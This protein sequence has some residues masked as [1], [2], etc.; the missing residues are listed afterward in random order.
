MESYPISC[1]DSG[2][3]IRPLCCG[4][5]YAPHF[6]HAITATVI[7]YGYGY[8][9]RPRKWTP[10]SS[11]SWHFS[12][13]PLFPS[14]LSFRLFVRPSARSV[15]VRPSL[16]PDVAETR[17]ERGPSDGASGALCD[18]IKARRHR[19]EAPFSESRWPREYQTKKT[20]DSSQVGHYIM[21]HV[22]SY[23]S[24]SVHSGSCDDT[25]HAVPLPGRRGSR[26]IRHIRT[27]SAR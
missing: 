11:H 27:G 13:A 10:F 14:S 19:G 24:I 23:G 5:P 26:S 25:L 16:L 6:L 1:V 2:D 21:T 4:A 9:R 8:G 20:T 3:R 22:P 12:P 18:R 17:N 15:R 7:T